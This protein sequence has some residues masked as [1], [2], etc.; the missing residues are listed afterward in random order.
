[1]TTTT[2]ISEED[3]GPLLLLYLQQLGLSIVAILVAGIYDNRLWRIILILLYR[4]ATS[5]ASSI[6]LL[7]ITRSDSEGSSS[8]P[9]SSSWLSFFIS[10]MTYV[11]IWWIPHL[12]NL[13][14]NQ[15]QGCI[16]VTGVSSGMGQ[17]TVEYFAK[18]NGTG[19][20]YGSKYDQIFALTSS[21]IKTCQE[22]YQ[23]VLTKDQLECIT[24]VSMNVTQLSSI[25]QA[26][27]IVEEWITQNN[28]SI[29]VTGIVLYHGIPHVGPA[30]YTPIKMYQD[31]FNVNF[32]G[33]IHIVQQFLP[34]L[35]R[36][37]SSSTSDNKRIIVTG[38]GGSTCTPCPPLLSA[39]MSSKFAM[40]AYIQC[41]RQELYMTQTGIE[42]CV[43]NPG[44]V[45]T[46]FGPKGDT[47][48]ANYYTE[49]EKIS[50]NSN[51]KRRI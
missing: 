31:V 36:S 2:T 26:V 47:I 35:R 14:Y 40:E 48:L 19:G 25:Q 43:I 41:L 50:G 18:T 13:K 24:F 9:S 42:A 20:K 39:Y 51:A 7:A 3:G 8:S 15:R 45:E 33:T 34:L 5:A 38:T 21:N 46:K 1:M 30:Q 23:T 4:G 10:V 32:L 17:A 27:R 49:C 16:I 12:T 6:L 28:N 22:Y 11:G 44:F 37:S 29:G